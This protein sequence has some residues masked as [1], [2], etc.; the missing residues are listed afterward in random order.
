MILDTIFANT[1]K[2]MYAHMINEGHFEIIYT[3]FQHSTINLW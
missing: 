1:A 3:W 2:D